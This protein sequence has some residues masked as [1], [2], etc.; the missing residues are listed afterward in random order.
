MAGVDLRLLA[1]L[2]LWF[3]LLTPGCIADAF[4]LGSNRQHIR[5]DGLRR[6]LVR[7]DGGAVECWVARSPSA[8]EGEAEAFVLFFVGK[9]DRAE[10]WTA[11]VAG[12]WG[13]RPVEVWGVNYPGSGGSD[14]AARLAHVTPA[15]L[16]V[17]DAMSERAAGRPIFAQAASFGTIAALAVAARRPLT[18]LVLESPPPLRQLILGGHGWWN[19]W[20][21]AGLAASQVPADLDSLASARRATAPAVFILHGAEEVVPPKYQQRVVDAYAGPKQVIPMPGAR[22]AD[23]LT[24]VVADKRG[25]CQALALAGFGPLIIAPSWPASAAGVRRCCRR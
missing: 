25:A 10:R 6:E 14:G 7:Y 24:R 1:F 18:G 5:A 11:A 22:H 17:F 2:T 3:C 4:V 15:A 21:L 20:L 8:G 19:L 12:A 9:T 16:A 23:A 13:D